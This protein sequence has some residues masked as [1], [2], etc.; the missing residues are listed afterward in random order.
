MTE[1]RLLH[2]ASCEY[3]KFYRY[4]STWMKMLTNMFRLFIEKKSSQP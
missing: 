1:Q 2:V 4:R 3:K